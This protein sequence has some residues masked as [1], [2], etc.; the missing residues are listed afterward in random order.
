MD[1][2]ASLTASPMKEAKRRSK[3]KASADALAAKRT[4]TLRRNAAEALKGHLSK[5]EVTCEAEEIVDMLE[6]AEDGDEDGLFGDD[7]MERLAEETRDGKTTALVQ[8]GRDLQ[9]VF[10]GAETPIVFQREKAGPADG[11]VDQGSAI[12]V[13]A[14]VFAPA[15][16]LANQPEVS[17][18]AMEEELRA[19]LGGA[20][21]SKTLSQ[22][23]LSAVLEKVS[24]GL[25]AAVENNIGSAATIATGLGGEEVRRSYNYAAI[26]PGKTVQ[27]LRSHFLHCPPS[28]VVAI[29]MTPSRVPT[30]L[31]GADA[32]RA[33]EGGPLVPRV[34]RST[35]AAEAGGGSS[36]ARGNS[37]AAPA[38]EVLPAPGV[39]DETR[40]LF[41]GLTASLTR[42]LENSFQGLTAQVNGSLQGVSGQ[43]TDLT[44][45]IEQLERSQGRA[46]EASTS[47][48]PPELRGFSPSEVD[49]YVD[50]AAADAFGLSGVLL[51]RPG[52][53]PVRI[54]RQ[55]KLFLE[56]GRRRRA[57]GTAT[58]GRG[59]EPDARRGVGHGAGSGPWGVVGG[60]GE[61]LGATGPYVV[62]APEPRPTDG[63]GGF[64]SAGRGN[65]YATGHG[66]RADGGH[67]VEARGWDRGGG[68]GLRGSGSY[69]GAIGE[70][71]EGVF[72][73]PSFV[74]PSL[75]PLLTS[76]TSLLPHLL[77]EGIIYLSPMRPRI[78]G[79][80]PNAFLIQAATGLKF[81]AVTSRMVHPATGLAVVG[82][83]VALTDMEALL[84]D[85]LPLAMRATNGEPVAASGMIRAG[86]TGGAKSAVMTEPLTLR[87]PF[88]AWMR[89]AAMSLSFLYDAAE[90]GR[91]LSVRATG[92]LLGAV[93]GSAFA[94]AQ[95]V[96]AFLDAC[97]ACLPNIAN[98]LIKTRTA[99]LLDRSVEAGQAL[100]QRLVLTS[101]TVSVRAANTATTALSQLILVHAALEGIFSGVDAGTF[102]IDL[103]SPGLC[104][105][106]GPNAKAAPGQFK[107]I[108]HQ[109]HVGGETATDEDCLL[110]G[111][112]GQWGSAERIRW[113]NAAEEAARLDGLGGKN[114]LLHLC[115][116][117]VT[118]VNGTDHPKA[119]SAAQPKGGGGS[120][121]E[122]PFCSQ[123]PGDKGGH[124]LDKCP[125]L[126]DFGKARGIAEQGRVQAGIDEMRRLNADLIDELLN[127]P[128]LFPT[129]ANLLPGGADF[130][131]PPRE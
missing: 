31:G 2:L 69:G 56:E 58:R 111:A 127:R 23:E 32:R 129:L 99:C 16:A 80:S 21:L 15:L 5:G 35:P 29:S 103:G 39:S 1:S 49:R 68:S 48:L 33:A 45:R 119:K 92:A 7:A 89:E 12:K 27:V 24:K 67:H 54:H 30:S 9:A 87:H 38:A 17:P 83:P 81:D 105:Y 115:E 114:T 116:K 100:F 130:V 78:L 109:A 104:V 60:Y 74:E 55:V 95:R 88:L 4:A 11:E 102:H 82:S 86:T 110:G 73:E 8:L 121:F 40:Q 61:G 63:P 79:V 6:T 75:S 126:V 53:E 47:S 57:G 19:I 62:R 10:K 36:G 131:P 52:A 22:Q 14:S 26:D 91:K 43:V 59:E 108:I 84:I 13:L 18:A 46:P 93:Q 37:T 98:G 97:E 120:G 96:G 122:C 123:G 20:D 70:D 77:K 101:L 76:R 106:M 128:F 66:P 71:W 41:A 125:L 124:R 64:P 90:S 118:Y 25:V 107:R 28:D 117:K 44:K 85:L 50:M 113:F 51:E 94:D 112:S 65:S 72:G 34:H 3:A 42:S